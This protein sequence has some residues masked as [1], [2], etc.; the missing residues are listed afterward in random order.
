M[1]LM[2][3]RNLNNLF[4]MIIISIVPYFGFRVIVQALFVSFI[5]GYTAQLLCGLTKKYNILIYMN[6]I[7]FLSVPFQCLSLVSDKNILYGMVFVFVALSYF[8]LTIKKETL[9]VRDWIYGIFALFILFQLRPEGLL[10]VIIYLGMLLLSSLVKKTHLQINNILYKNFL[11]PTITFFI[12]FMFSIT[13]IG[14]KTT[15][16]S[17][18]VNSTVNTIGLLHLFANPDI[19][20]SDPD[21]SKEDILVAYNYSQFVTDRWIK[22]KGFST[23][24]LVEKAYLKSTK[25]KYI[26]LIV[27][28]PVQIFL[29][30]IRIFAE[31]GNCLGKP[32][33]DD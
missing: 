21:E 4:T 13:W 22:E 23:I 25:K 12:V 3:D 18:Y 1:L 7:L 2:A 28:N 9:V 10:P 27:E 8:G 30:R 11:R 24:C 16:S 5:I 6:I 31:Q 29:E 33:R 19:D 17:G 26:R 32:V 14:Y 20:D 15:I